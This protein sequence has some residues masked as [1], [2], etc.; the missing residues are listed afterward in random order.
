MIKKN[1]KLEII[2]ILL[3]NIGELR[4]I[5]AISG[6]RTPKEIPAVFHNGST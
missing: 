3:E 6:T 4:I 1:I 2:L 5:S